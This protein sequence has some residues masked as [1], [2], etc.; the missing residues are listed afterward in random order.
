VPVGLAHY[1]CAKSIE[2]VLSADCESVVQQHFTHSNEDL[3]SREALHISKSCV[4]TACLSSHHDI[5]QKSNNTELDVL[6][7]HDD[8][9]TSQTVDLCLPQWSLQHIDNK[10]AKPS[11]VPKLCHLACRTSETTFNYILSEYANICHYKQGDHAELSADVQKA[12]FRKTDTWQ[13]HLLEDGMPQIL[14]FYQTQHMQQFPKC[15]RMLQ[16]RAAEV[17]PATKFM[18]N[19]TSVGSQCGPQF[20]KLSA[21]QVSPSKYFTRS[22]LIKLQLQHVTLPEDVIVT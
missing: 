9:V 13:C 11:N 8:N 22:E 20:D 16:D 19:I 7:E 15:A 5:C 3:S 6:S 17:K 2:S 21:L 12:D 1:A 10:P 4:N 18:H 14:C